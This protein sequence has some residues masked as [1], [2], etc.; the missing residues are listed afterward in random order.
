LSTSRTQRFKRIVYAYNG[1]PLFERKLYV[2]GVDS[3][4]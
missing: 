4:I 3:Q 2:L 1:Q